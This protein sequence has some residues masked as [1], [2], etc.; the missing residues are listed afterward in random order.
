MADLPPAAPPIQLLADLT[1]ANIEVNAGYSGASISVF[2][3]VFVPKGNPAD[4]VVVV[5]GPDQPVS[6]ARRER[7]AGLWLNGEPADVSGAP[8]F[9]LTAASRTLSRIADPRTLNHA[10]VG[11]ESL[12]FSVPG[13]AEYRQ[14]F[15]R[16]KVREGLY[17]EDPGGVDFVDR[18]LFRAEVDLPV[19]APVGQYR[20][21]VLL[22]QD[23]QP[24][25]RRGRDL[26]IEK[27]GVERLISGFAQ[28]RP[29]AYGMVC[30][31]IAL[32]AG[33]AASAAF[34]RV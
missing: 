6:I 27:V 23:G 10:G 4:V 28:Q 33:W 14:A 30:V 29:W 20:V 18:G 19:S 3:A 2:G 31:L 8:G 22:F 7:R 24:V 34:R 11:L 5:R 16:L 1:N 13:G 21:E 15:I 26:T 25:A 12:P 32:A 17:V 9:H